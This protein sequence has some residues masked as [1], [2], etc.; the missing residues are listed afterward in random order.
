[1]QTIQNRLYKTLFIGML[2]LSSG[3][4]ARAQWLKDTPQDALEQQLQHPLPDAA[5]I[6]TKVR[7]TFPDQPVQLT[8]D[9]IA[10]DKR[11]QITAERRL[12]AWLDLSSSP[13]RAEYV[14]SDAFGEEIARLSITRTDRETADI[15]YTAANSDA[16]EPINLSTP[17]DGLD[18]SWSD[19]SFAFLWWTNATLIEMD[20][21]LN[22]DC[23]VIEVKPPPGT[24][25]DYARTRL[26]IDE[27]TFGLLQAQGYET[28]GDL[29][30][31]L[32]VK[33]LRKI[34]DLRTIGDVET[35]SYPQRTKTRLRIR[36]MVL[37]EQ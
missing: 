17:I 33:S 32:Q 1:M 12:D 3:A 6:L 20:S 24:T 30:K 31:K 5:E 28:S 10:K 16:P 18:F 36:D 26:W 37:D 27:K 13:A 21:K 14:L 34:N 11:G 4:P 8:A 7:Q 2:I 35:R 9:L 25:S 22:R 19:L 23:Y 15:S 29:R